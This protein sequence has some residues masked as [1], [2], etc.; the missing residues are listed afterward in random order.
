MLSPPEKKTFWEVKSAS[1]SPLPN[2]AN[3]ELMFRLV[4]SSPSLVCSSMDPRN[5]PWEDMDPIL[6]FSSPTSFVVCPEFCV[7]GA[8]LEKTSCPSSPSLLLLLLLSSSSSPLWESMRP[9]ITNSSFESC[10]DVTSVL[11]RNLAMA[12]SVKRLS[13]IM[14]AVC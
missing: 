11:P 9:R 8:M 10:C 4:P 7:M 14:A 2:T 6:S 3:V 12:V 5:G 13:C 1:L